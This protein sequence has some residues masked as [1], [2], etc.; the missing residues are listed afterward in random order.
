MSLEEQEVLCSNCFETVTMSQV[1]MHSSTCFKG[2][3]LTSRS[4]RYVTEDED[5]EHRARTEEINQRLFKLIETM[6]LK[7]NNE[8]KNGRMIAYDRDDL[9]QEPTLMQKII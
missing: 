3:E 7:S 6:F 8:N 5:Q 1:D 2:S 9:L 4:H